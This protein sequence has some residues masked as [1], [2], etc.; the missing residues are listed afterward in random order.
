MDDLDLPKDAK[1][2]SFIAQVDK[3]LKSFEYSTEWAD[4]ISA[5]GRLIKVIQSNTKCGYVPR[6]FVIGKRLAQ[7]LH[8][9]LP[10]GVHCKALECYDVIFRTIGPERVAYDLYVYGPGLFALLEPSAMTVKSP[11]F[12][13]YE[14]HLLPLGKLL[15]PSFLGLLKGLLPGLEPGAEFSER[16]N[17]MLE[18]FSSSVGSAFFYTCLWELLIRCPSIRQ[19]GIS[20]ILNHLNKRKLLN[21]QSYIYGLD[22]NILVESLCC[23]F[24]DSVLLVQRDALDFILLALPIHFYST[25]E[26]NPFQFITSQS[27]TVKDFAK[28]CTASLSILLRRDASLNRRLFVWLKGGQSVEGMVMDSLDNQVGVSQS[29]TW[30]DIVMDKLDDKDVLALNGKHES[31]SQRYFKLYSQIILTE[32]VRRLIH[33]PTCLPVPYQ[34]NENHLNF[35]TK[36]TF[37]S[38]LS[39]LVIERSISERPFRILVGLID[40]PDI[41]HGLLDNLLLDIMWYTYESYFKLHWQTTCSMMNSIQMQKLSHRD[42][43]LTISNLVN[44]PSLC[45]KQLPSNMINLIKDYVFIRDSVKSSSLRIDNQDRNLEYDGTTLNNT[46]HLADREDSIPSSDSNIKK[47]S[48]QN[49]NHH[50]HYPTITTNNNVVDEFLRT[51]HL[52]F[53][54]ISS[55]FLWKFIE[56]QFT[57]LLNVSPTVTVNT[58]IGSIKCDDWQQSSLKLSFNQWCSIV[59]FLLNCLPM[60]MYP[61]VRGHYLPHLITHLTN[62]LVEKLRVN[63]E[64]HYHGHQSLL[65]Q[66]GSFLEYK[67]T[68]LEWASIINCLDTIVHHI[69]EYA[70]TVFDQLSSPV[71]LKRQVESLSSNNNNNNSSNFSQCNEINSN[72]GVADGQDNQISEELMMI[73]EAVGQFRRFLGIFCIHVLN[74]SP[75]KMNEFIQKISTEPCQHDGIIISY[76]GE[77]NKMN[78][79]NDGNNEDVLD[80]EGAKEKSHEN[81]V[82]KHNRQV[83]SSSSSSISCID[84]FAQICRLIVEMSSFPLSI[85]HQCK[86][87]SMSPRIISSNKSDLSILDLFGGELIRHGDTGC[88]ILPQWLVCLLYAS[89]DLDNFNIKSIALYTLIELFHAAVSIHGWS[90]EFTYYSND[91]NTTTTTTDNN[92]SSEENHR[93][94]NNENGDKV[95]PMDDKHDEV[96]RGMRLVFPVLSGELISYLSQKTNLFTYLGVSLWRYLSPEYSTYHDDTTSLLVRLHQLAPPLP[97]SVAFQLTPGLSGFPSNI[98][99]C[100]EGFILSQMLSSDLDIKIDAHSR[101]ILLWHLLRYYG[102]RVQSNIHPLTNSSTSTSVNQFPVTKRSLH[103]SVHDSFRLSGVS[104]FI[105]AVSWRRGFLSLTGDSKVGNSDLSSPGLGL[106]DIPFYRCTLLLLDNL[107]YDNPLGPIGSIGLTNL[108]SSH[109]SQCNL[110]KNEQNLGHNEELNQMDHPIS[111]GNSILREQSI[112]WLEKALRTGQIDRLIAPIL[113]ILLHPSTA[114]ISLKSHVLKHYCQQM[115]VS[116]SSKSF[117]GSLK[118]VYTADID[119]KP[120]SYEEVVNKMNSTSI[121]SESPPHINRIHSEKTFDLMNSIRAKFQ[122]F[123]STTE[124]LNEAGVTNEIHTSKQQAA[125]AV[126]NS[127]LSMRLMQDEKN[128]SLLDYVTD[129]HHDSRSLSMLPV[130]EHLLVYLQNYDSNQVIYAFS[131]L[132]SILSIAPGLFVRSLASCT[133]NSMFCYNLYGL[134]FIELLSRHRRSMA[135]CNFFT[136]ASS[137]E[138]SQSQQNY[139]N[140]LELI[141]DLCLQY[142]CSYLPFITVTTTTTPTVNTTVVDDDDHNNRTTSSMTNTSKSSIQFSHRFG[143][144]KREFRSNQYVQNTAAEILTLIVEQLISIQD[145]SFNS[146]LINSTLKSNSSLPNVKNTSSGTRIPELSSSSSVYLT[147]STNPNVVPPNTITFSSMIQQANGR[148]LVQN[149][150]HHTCLPSVVLHCLASCIMKVHWPK[151]DK[152][153]SDYSMPNG[154]KQLPICLQLILVNDILSSLSK[155][156]QTAQLQT[157]LKLFNAIL[158]LKPWYG[159][160]DRMSLVKHHQIS[161]QTSTELC[162]SSN[163]L[164]WPVSPSILLLDNELTS[165][166]LLTHYM[167]DIWSIACNKLPNAL[168]HEPLFRANCL[169]TLWWS[170][171]SK[172]SSSMISIEK[173]QVNL[174]IELLSIGLLSPSPPSSSNDN[175]NYTSFFTARLDL[176]SLWYSFV[177]KSL[178][179]W[180]WFIGSLIRVTMKQ[181]CSSL[182]KLCDRAYQDIKTRYMNSTRRSQLSNTSEWE[183]LPPDY[184]LTVLA[185]IQGICHTFLLS[186]G[187]SSLLLTSSRKVNSLQQANASLRSGGNP[188][189]VSQLTGLPDSIEGALEIAEIL[190]HHKLNPPNSSGPIPEVSNTVPAF[191]PLFP[192]PLTENVDHCSNTINF[193]SMNNPSVDNVSNSEPSVILTSGIGDDKVETTEMSVHS[194]SSTVIFLNR[195]KN[196]KNVNIKDDVLNPELHPYVQAQMEVLRLMPDIISSLSFL[197]NTLNQSPFC[198]LNK[199]NFYK[200]TCTMI[201]RYPDKEH[202]SLLN[203]PIPSERLSPLISL[204]S[205]TLVRGA[206]RRLLKPIATQHPDLLLITTAVAWPNTTF[207][208]ET[209]GLLAGVDALINYGPLDMLIPVRM[210][211]DNGTSEMY[212]IPLLQKQISLL[213]LISGRTYDDKHYGPIISS[214]IL[215][216]NLR[217]SIRRPMNNS[218]LV[219]IINTI[220]CS[221]HSTLL[222]SSMGS[223]SPLQEIQTSLITSGSKVMS[224][225]NS[226]I[227]LIRLQTNLL[228]LFYAWLI[229]KSDFISSDLLLILIRDL[230]NLPTIINY[231]HTNIMNITTTTTSSSSSILGLSP[232]GIFILIKIFSKFLE[233]S[234]FSDDK[235]EQKELQELCH[236]LIETT[237]AIAASALHQPSWFRKTLQVR[238]LD[239]DLTNSCTYSQPSNSVDLTDRISLSG[240]EVFEPINKSDRIRSGSSDLTNSHSFGQFNT[241]NDSLND[242]EQSSV[243]D[244]YDK[245][246]SLPLP[247]SCYSK[248]RHSSVNL[249]SNEITRIRMRSDVTIQA[250]ELLTE[251]MAIFLDLVYK[252]DEKDRVS[253]FLNN[254]LCNIFPYLRVRTL[255]NSDHFTVASKLIAS[256]SSYQYTRK[257]WRRDVLDLFYEPIFFQMSPVALQSWNLIIDN[258]MTQDK[259]T[260]KEA[261]ARLV[262]AQPGGLNLF[263]SKES[264]Y[265]QRAA[266]LKKLSYL[267][268]ASEPDQY[269]KAMPD[270]LER[271]AECLRLGQGIIPVVHT[272]VFLFARVLISRM[273]AIQLNSLWPIVVPEL[274]LTFKS[275][276][277]AIQ[278]CVSKIQS[279]KVKPD[280]STSSSSSFLSTSQMNLYISACKLLATS[281]LYPEYRLPQFSY[282][283][284]AFVKDLNFDHLTN[285]EEMTNVTILNNNNNRRTSF[286]PFLSDVLIQIERLQEVDLSNGIDVISTEASSNLYQS[287]FS[288]LALDKLVNIYSLKPFFESLHN[289]SNIDSSQ[290]S[291]ND[292]PILDSFLL[293]LAIEASLAQ[294]FPEMIPSR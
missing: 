123:H 60:D 52:F 239:G 197:W 232:A 47:L 153:W 86:N 234:N 166:D 11:L 115:K 245:S 189:T 57:K 92:N 144:S 29:M 214:T 138:L 222:S 28:L 38:D 236:R 224:N 75:V 36:S 280:T 63:C 242:V 12:D 262:F 102:S 173:D 172:S 97:K 142:M 259:S 275:L 43:T 95:V 116:T 180:G 70:V 267:V 281:L 179:Y 100:I 178:S 128:H 255:S 170:S 174:F 264:E 125:E 253:T 247:S 72:Y 276:S 106:Y 152:N 23:L 205:A 134:K 192:S 13:I 230:I 258:L 238:Q 34:L 194:P 208:I 169:T 124:L 273:S 249:L 210:K 185:L 226:G 162:N 33:N 32:A 256:I 284:W 14:E 8:P 164:L 288:I 133:M 246:I 51:S 190:Y 137:E 6:S 83:S 160:C 151:T 131:R 80:K 171:S 193:V 10:A 120:P 113:A 195:V 198:Q 168:N 139:T 289:S 272:Q 228:H 46:N 21:N 219:P 199:G 293:E 225:T 294:E 112:V 196:S 227:N 229:M 85:I 191:D 290:N 22:K 201:S 111:F 110:N 167:T 59:H 216:N 42:F 89:C 119:C 67:L 132:R 25:T 183:L 211:R 147:G 248:S 66:D 101:F 69:R 136:A 243:K 165:Y 286:L 17:R 65:S 207:D 266:C 3:S 108:L 182:N 217:D 15:H 156:F 78:G 187:N 221:Y 177:F 212:S 79:H 50:H 141:M 140:L 184:T 270:L 287:C 91:I 204:G 49:S 161:Q 186:V 117:N 73:A 269:A 206:I 260:F 37:G 213:D 84:L 74:F 109:R 56:N 103:S 209:G 292:I 291:F 200:S 279:R 254:I 96:N 5:L 145:E 18:M 39:A 271:L 19:Y 250:I 44:R 7:C 150:I 122:R 20:F 175:S 40:H 277:Q 241:A 233:T 68:S 121:N 54:N 71:N 107:D 98:S 176:H 127:V 114:R 48:T 285:Q 129:W 76:E 41:G 87:S 77:I 26:C 94:N 163:H 202:W 278:E 188:P 282:Y 240:S 105:A 99:S 215:I 283:Q 45:D 126:L 218:F 88:F 244:L 62:C 268:Y 9:A 130:N 30:A 157:F 53:S 143:Y 27:L 1:Y 261:L 58:M 31:N 61:N 81:S 231:N 104:N 257:S 252:S 181:I 203:A 235:R 159:Y 155:S 223:Y 274:F 93:G 237:A 16:G 220:Q 2:K 158:H 24:G 64:L 90:T 55:E 146:S 82:L 4:L 148:R 154:I 265:D 118:S 135:G 263:T 251:N 149:T 35:S